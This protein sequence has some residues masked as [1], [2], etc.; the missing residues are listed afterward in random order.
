MDETI[1]DKP[2]FIELNYKIRYD[3]F[4]ILVKKLGQ[5]W[6]LGTGVV[7][8]AHSL[9]H[10]IPKFPCGNCN[11]ENVKV[12]AAQWNV[13]SHSGDKYWECEIACGDCVKYTQRS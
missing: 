1:T 4:Q 6:Y 2:R 5:E 13:S 11:S 10:H 8:E 12:I 3:K 9:K 7:W